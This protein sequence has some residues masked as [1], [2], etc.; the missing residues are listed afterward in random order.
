MK[1]YYRVPHTGSEYR[2]CDELTDEV[3]AIFY[4]QQDAIDYVNW[5]NT[6]KK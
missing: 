4:N 5:K 6:L 3:I 1:L 2:V